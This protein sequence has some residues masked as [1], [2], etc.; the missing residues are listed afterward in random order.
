MRVTDATT[1]LF[2]ETAVVHLAD[3]DGD[4]LDDG[5]ERA[6]GLDPTVAD[7][8]GADPDGDGATHAAEQAAGTRGD[9]RDSTA[10]GSTTATRPPPRR[11]IPTATATACSTAPRP[12]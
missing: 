6:S 9:R 8:P 2:V 7:P 11:A 3:M 4:G 1:A 12:R 5:W 10:T